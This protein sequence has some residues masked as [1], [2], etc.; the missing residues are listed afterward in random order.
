MIKRILCALSLLAVYY[1]CNEGV[2][3]KEVSNHPGQQLAVQH[4]Q[5]CHMHVD[6]SVL[7]V[8]IWKND[9]LPKMAARMG[10][11]TGRMEYID[12]LKKFG[13]F[14]H[15]PL[16]SN[17]DWSLIQDY[18]ISLAPLLLESGKEANNYTGLKNFDLIIP[19]LP[20]VSPFTTFV[21]INDRENLLY[22]GNSTSETLNSFSFKSNDLQSVQVPG[23]LS[24]L[25]EN[26]E[27][28]IV[29]TM[30]QV[31]PHNFELGSL[32][33]VTKMNNGS[34]LIDDVLI[35]NLQRPVHCTIS[36]LDL[37]GKNDIIISSFGNIGGDLSWHSDFTSAETIR[38]QLKDI[39][40]TVK[41]EIVDF[42]NDKLPD[43]LALMAQGDEGFSVFIN[44]GSGKFKEERLLRFPPTYGST[45]FE[46][47]DF[48]HDGFMDI[49]YVNGDNGDYFPIVKSYHGI[50]LFLNDGNY[51]FKEEFFLEHHGAFKAIA[52]DFDQDGDYDISAIS[53]FPD[54][55]KS[56]PE[57]FVLYINTGNDNFEKQVMNPGYL[58]KWLAMDTGDIDADGDVDIILGSALFMQ[59]EVPE[60]IRSKWRTEAPPFVLLENKLR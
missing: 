15:Q 41:T 2:N 25:K 55:S 48:N 51:N 6:P 31:M 24:D 16:I 53:Y 9:V 34:F 44:L 28:L 7:P 19:D 50:R 38:H 42:N 43:I 33:T 32:S 39:S 57:D 60:N 40:G 12:Q 29:L 14:P 52:E 54:Y 47:V 45:Y 27:K 10:I 17:E 22:F 4:C 1:A 46:L 3:K 13:L 23:A 11:N 49:L 36:D 59:I 37:D 8:S 56:N 5:S 18:Y 20:G 58:G 35:K 30:G 21:Q 26:E